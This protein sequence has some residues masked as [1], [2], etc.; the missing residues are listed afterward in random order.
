MANA[1]QLGGLV[2]HLTLVLED[3]LV[4]N[5]SLPIYEMLSN[6]PNVRSLF[7]VHQQQDVA[8]HS[9]THHALEKFVH[10][11]SI[12]LQEKEYDPTYTHVSMPTVPNTETF[13]HTFL[14]NALKVHS[15]RLRA[16]HLYTLL[17]LD[18]QLY[19]DIRDKTPNLRAVTFTTNI[20]LD[21]EGVFSEATP[22]ASGQSGRLES[23]T[24]LGCDGIH[25]DQFAK[26][27]LCGVYGVWLKD[28]Q[29]IS[30]GRYIAHIPKPPS[31]PVFTSIER[32]H[33][34]HINAQELSVIALISIEELSLTCITHDA[35]CRLPMHL[36]GD[37]SRCSG[38]RLGFM[39]LRRLR[40]SPKL[41]TEASWKKL[42][43]ELKAVYKEL[44]ER[45]LPLRGIQLT[46]DA[47]DRRINCGCSDHEWL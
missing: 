2:R 13:F 7:I 4:D 24:F 38:T 34:D 23:L 35:F 36:E 22:W 37:L 8:K 30:S 43:A 10:L 11:E 6:M 3:G 45:C 16:L 14:C 1:Q 39:G 9:S 5:N 44:R 20:C 19:I 29:F 18:P 12:T 31:T 33:F 40:L 25:A 47:V 26:N 27:V 28:V 21:M 32:M 41:A 42:P 15:G 46:L 17:P